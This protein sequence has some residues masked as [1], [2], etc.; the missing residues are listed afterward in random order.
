MKPWIPSKFALAAGGFISG[1]W[2]GSLCPWGWPLVGLLALFALISLIPA[3]TRPA[4]LLFFFIALGVGRMT[5][6]QRLTAPVL[7]AP[8]QDIVAEGLVVEVRPG[9]QTVGLEVRTDAY[10]RLLVTTDLYPE[11]RYGD[12]LRLAGRLE[13]PENF[14]TASGREFDYV[15]YLARQEIYYQI[16]RPRIELLARGEGAK[17]AGALQSLNQRFITSIEKVLPEPQAGLLAG[18][19][20][21]AR[22]SLDRDLLEDFRRVGLSHMIVLSGYNLTIVAEAIRWS[23]GFLPLPLYASLGAG[24]LGV[25]AFA[26][27]AGGGAAVWRATLMALLALVARATGRIYEVGRALL[28]T[29]VLLLLWDPVYLVFDL[30]FQLSILA[31]LGLIYLSPLFITRLRFL[32]RAWGFREVVASTVAAQL[33]VLPWLLYATGELSLVALL[34]NPLVLIVV[35]AIMLSG[36]I[37]VVA[38]LIN[39]ALATLPAAVAYALISYQLWLI[40]LFARLPG[41]AVTLRSFPLVFVLA[42]YALYFYCYYRHRSALTP[43][44]R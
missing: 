22:R 36:F 29:V 28:V 15:A 25:L 10:G 11:Y 43:E 35:P 17:F 7:G 3:A 6:D 24:G 14:L 34:I 23:L 16:F 21:G 31:T 5:L 1:V 40:E 37:A 27:M 32:P 30:G 39:A 26:L 8:G 42:V 38:G 41:A 13:R 44:R 18:L 2:L 20:L 12:R 33:A 19:I 9:E 4:A